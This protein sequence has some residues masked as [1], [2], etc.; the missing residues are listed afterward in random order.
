MVRSLR[1]AKPGSLCQRYGH[2]SETFCTSLIQVRG[3]RTLQRMLPTGLHW[4]ELCVLCTTAMSE[5]LSI[6]LTLRLGVLGNHP[7]FTPS[8]G[9]QH[10][11]P[12]ANHCSQVPC[13]M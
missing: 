7:S 3:Q 1:Q 9:M 2:A 6:S 12:E 10:P 11:V 8:A 4:R 13:N 5:L